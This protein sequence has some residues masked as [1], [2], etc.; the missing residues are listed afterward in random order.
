MFQTTLST[1]V[2]ANWWL[3]SGGLKEINEGGLGALPFVVISLL[4]IALLFI[5]YFR[6]TSA[7]ERRNSLGPRT[8]KLSEPLSAAHRAILAE[9]SDYYNKL[10][11]ADKEI[12]E[13]RVRHYMSSKMFTT[14]DGYAII[15][16]MKVMIAATSVQLTFGLPLASNSNFTHILIMPNAEMT[17]R[18]ATRHTI[19][20]PWRE[21]VD[22]YSQHDD[23]QN[24]GLK[25]MATALVRDNRLQEKNYKIF[26]PKKYEQWEKI[27]ER[28]VEN[29]M[30]GMFQ[31]IKTDDRV[32][33]EYFAQAVVYFFELPVA[34]KTKYPALFEAMAGLLK[35][36]TVSRVIRK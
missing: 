11:K 9:K 15:D 5:I 33:E 29:F 26:S 8:A 1:I 34:F 32:R 36:D 16:E 12:F 25:V 30:S 3:F 28:E 35:Q 27:S 23:G 10:G 24:E 22:G 19:V 6:A 13:K 17:P 14:E 31:N 18:S 20:V 21:F 7:I 2:F 4:F